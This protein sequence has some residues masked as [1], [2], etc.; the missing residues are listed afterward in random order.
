LAVNAEHE[1]LIIRNLANGDS[2]AFAPPLIINEQ[3]I[4][5]VFVR[6]DRAFQKT[7]DWIC[8]RGYHQQ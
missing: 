3:E 6:F 7:V 5:E 8:E 4:D 1:G 2:I